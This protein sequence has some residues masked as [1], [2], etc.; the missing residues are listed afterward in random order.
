[1]P[2]RRG[3]G[4]WA[5]VGVGHG[6]RLNV[7]YRRPPKIPT[8]ICRGASW[9]LF[10]KSPLKNQ[11]VHGATIY[12]INPPI[13]TQY[14]RKSRHSRENGNLEAGVPVGFELVKH[15][16]CG[17]PLGWG[18]G[19]V[20]RNRIAPSPGPR[21]ETQRRGDDG[22]IRGSSVTPR[23]MSPLELLELL[24]DGFGGNLVRE[25]PADA[26]PDNGARFVNQE[27]RRRCKA[28]AKQV[29][30]LVTRRDGTVTACVKHGELRTDLLNQG[31]RTFKIVRADRNHLGIEASD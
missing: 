30:D 11:A 10:Q 17:R 21:S 25:A 15:P 24:H 2:C 22:V 9:S 1:M 3:V 16:P 8:T 14:G 26:L 6:N 20:D 23:T 27:Y 18:A 29:E 28:I 13:N 7:Q 31:L 5:P 19:T 12:D 4:I